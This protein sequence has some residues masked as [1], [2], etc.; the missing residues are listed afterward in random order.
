MKQLTIALLLLGCSEQMNLQPQTDAGVMGDAWMESDGQVQ[1]DAWQAPQEDAGTD[2]GDPGADAGLP[3]DAADA[4][5]SVGDVGADGGRDA[6]ADAGPPRPEGEAVD[7]TGS[8]CALDRAGTMWC[9]GR[10]APVQDV[11]RLGTGFAS[12]SGS[13]ALRGH[14]VWC[15]E[16]HTPSMVAVI[17]GS[18]T[19][20]LDSIAEYS[21]LDRGC[22][23]SAAGEMV[24][25]TDGGSVTRWGAG[26]TQPIAVS[27][28]FPRETGA[29]AVGDEAYDLNPPATCHSDGHRAS[30]VHDTGGAFG[31][32]RPVGDHYILGFSMSCSHNSSGTYCGDATVGPSPGDVVI[33]DDGAFHDHAVAWPIGSATDW[34]ARG[35]CISGSTLRCYSSTGVLAY[36]VNW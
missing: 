14:E 20:I 16:F 11:R 27:A 34:T 17:D 10:W 23:L 24:C 13:C 22:G 35:L 12:A 4:G 15:A 19:L 9:W 33:P 30:C 26:L 31:L 36:T 28:T 29:G 5:S 32:E 18:S 21:D 8:R 7:V 3:P 2:A 1:A 6:Q 25:W